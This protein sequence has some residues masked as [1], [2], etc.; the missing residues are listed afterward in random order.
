[1][2]RLRYVYITTNN[3]NGKKYIGQ[4]TCPGNKTILTDNYLGSGT[5]II[6]AVNKYGKEN[7]SKI[8]IGICSTQKQVDVMEK[9]YIDIYKAYNNKRKWYNIN[10]GGQYVR[11]LDHAS[12]MSIIM[13]KFY[14]DPE[15]VNKAVAA[16]M[17]LSVEEYK[18]YKL[19]KKLLKTLKKH[20][21]VLKLR[22]TEIRNVEKKKLRQL[23]FN[24][25]EYKNEKKRKR[26]LLSIKQ[27]ND[28]AFKEAVRLGKEKVLKDNPDLYK[29]PIKTQEKIKMSKSKVDNPTYLHRLLWKNN[30]TLGMVN[31]HYHFILKKYVLG[32]SLMNIEIRILI[33]SET[34][35][36]LQIEHDIEIL[37]KEA[38]QLADKKRRK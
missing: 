18:L 14:S 9:Q 22:E 23:Y 28:P 27:K 36:N 33:V 26:D 38:Y 6:N 20:K 35:N 4:R 29:R 25:E 10:H 24:S 5:A 12:N 37:K 7:F 11:S 17:G 16:Q 8:V 13:K 32:Y 15:N 34:L 1:M 19:R 21:A 30:L 31:K 3:L 2:I